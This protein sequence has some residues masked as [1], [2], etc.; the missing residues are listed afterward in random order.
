M[1][2]VYE[3]REDSFLLS[4]W[5]EKLVQGSVL[6]MGT[7]SGIQAV[8]AAKNPKVT[9]VLAVDI[10]PKALD[11]TKKRAADEGISHKIELVLSDLFENVEGEFDW[12]LYNAPYLPSEGVANEESWTGGETGAENIIRFLEQAQAYLVNN[13]SILLIY[14]SETGLRKFHFGYEIEVL[15][16]RSL[17]FET[18]YC[19]KL[20]LL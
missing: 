11:A 6:D 14:S 7:G 1:E 17:F 10:N 2:K 8:T 13:G 5:V 12:I 3:P 9:K 20:S 16:S 19:V 18:I 4:K 15:E